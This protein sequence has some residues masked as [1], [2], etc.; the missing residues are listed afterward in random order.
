DLDASALESSINNIV[1]RHESLRTRFS[2]LGDRTVQ[3]ISPELSLN[4][5]AVDLR[6]IPASDR[7]NI[8]LR[9]AR[10]EALAPFDLRQLP[11][12]RT[13]LVR[14]S[15]VEHLL[16]L[17]MHHIISDRRSMEI[18]FAELAALYNAQLCGTPV[19]LPELS[20]QYAEYVLW[21]RH[22][23]DGDLGR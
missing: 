4:L 22:F 3:I 15:D 11:L 8:A 2:T 9:L 1:R 10:G 7:E 13:N 18:F 16:L 14:I 23:L 6:A 5:P 20:T 12:L 17:S 21:Q 19:V